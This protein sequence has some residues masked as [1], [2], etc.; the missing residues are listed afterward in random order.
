MAK[1]TLLAFALTFIVIAAAQYFMRR[2]PPSQPP[3]NQPQAQAPAR[4]AASP[5]QP[6]Q[7]TSS[8]GSSTTASKAAGATAPRVAQSE[9]ETV[10]ES[11]QFRVV[12]TNRG[13]QVKSWV[14]KKFFNDLREPLELVHPIAAPK[15]GYPLSLWTYDENLRTQLNSALYEVKST[16]SNS[17]PTRCLSAAPCLMSH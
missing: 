17:P 1:R 14:L 6:A 2:N 13:A 10:V 5:A 3:A 9:T 15:Y 7:S 11:D 8:P 4:P 12:F 16:D